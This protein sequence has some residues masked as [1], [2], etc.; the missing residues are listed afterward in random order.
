MQVKKLS[1]ATLV[2][3]AAVPFAAAS[4]A[5]AHP[6]PCP[7]GNA[8][9]SAIYAVNHGGS[10]VTELGGPVHGVYDGTVSP[11]LS[12]VECAVADAA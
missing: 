4:P 3:L 9:S 12:Q 10:D 8:A 5:Q 11:A 7:G 2:A 1:L 6:T